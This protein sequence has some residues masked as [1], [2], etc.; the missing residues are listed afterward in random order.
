MGIQ[1]IKWGTYFPRIP[2]HKNIMKKIL[3]IEDS[4]LFGKY[5]QTELTK[6]TGMSSKW[7]KTLAE[8]Q[9]IV[10]QFQSELFAAI[11]DINLPDAPG[12][13]ALDYVTSMNIPAVVLTGDCTEKIRKYVWSHKNVADYVVK[14]NKESVSYAVSMIHR[15]MKNQ[16]IKVL[17]A[18]DSKFMRKTITNL[19][20]I[21]QYIVFEASDGNEALELIEKN[22]DIKILIT[23]YE[24]PNT[25]GIELTKQIRKKFN[26]EQLAIIGISSQERNVTTAEFIKKGA[27]DFL[28]KPF[29]S[30]EFY[31]CIN[32]NI[33]ALEYI[34]EIKKSNQKLLDLNHLKNKFLGMAS[35]DL[36]N[37]IVSIRGFSEMLLSEDFGP[38][39]DSQKEFISTTNDV[40]NEMLAL[41]NELLDISIIESGKLQMELRPGKLHQ[42]VD[43][44]V[45][46]NIVNAEK[47]DIQLHST[48]DNIGE[49]IYDEKR[50]KQVIENLLS[51]AIKF[52][53]KGR[54]IYIYLKQENQWARV[55]IKD[56]GP[57]LSSED[58]SKLF[59]E[60]QRLSSQPTDGEKSTGLG[61]S[62]V[63]KIIDLHGGKIGVKSKLG[64]GSTFFFELPLHPE[65]TIT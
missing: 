27:N 59:G 5:I 55:S 48:L 40:S 54:H 35:H 30:E 32:Q 23:D 46:R 19:L 36:R 45:K 18:D 52:S 1:S 53:E 10:D 64:S 56:E 43:Q 24:M 21:H 65:K 17:V 26:K 12:G 60:F 50:I 6:V 57:G 38:L 61:L 14:D 39:N 51:N 4:L 58:Q 37:P 41:L 11:V 22:P 20:N 29:L 28:H 34:D 33:Q 63:K 2:G 3:I 15:I 8:T 42:L 16:S 9:Q 49:L 7:A 13:E 31:C 47:K 62:I 44:S 25:D